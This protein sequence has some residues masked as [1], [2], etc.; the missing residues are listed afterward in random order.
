[1]FQ[2]IQLK[3][4]TKNF[5]RFTKIP[6]PLTVKF[7]LFNVTNS[8][9]VLLGLE[10][11]HFQEVGPFVYQQWR[12][13]EVIDFLDNNRKLVYKEFKTFYP[14]FKPG[15]DIESAS[16]LDPTKHNV[17]IV[18]LPLLTVLTQLAQLEEGSLKRNLAAKAASRLIQAGGE[19]I[20]ITR[21]ANEF[22][23]DGYK[24]GLMESARELIS[25]T[26]GY[27][28]ESP[29]PRNKF[30]FFHTKNGTWSK[31]E[32]GELTVFTGRNNSMDDFM[33]VDNWNGL[34]QLNVWPRNTEAGNRCNE[35]RGTDGSQF[36]P[37]VTRQQVLEIFAPLVCTSIYIKYKEDTS[38]RGIPLFRF[39]TPPDVFAAPKKRPRNA[40]YCTIQTG[41]GNGNGPKSNNNNHLNQQPPVSPADKSQ[42]AS[43]HNQPARSRITNSRC[44]IDGLM[45]LS[46]CQKGAP[47]AASSPHFYNADPMLAMAAGLRPNKELHETYLDIEPMT[48]AVF[49]A[50]SRA[51]LNAYVEQAALEVVDSSLVGQM[52]PMVAPLLW[53]EEAAEIDDKSS[54]EFKGKLLNL[55]DKA[56]RSFLV[57]FV[58]GLLI[59]AAVAVQYW[60]ATCYKID[61]KLIAE[62]LAERRRRSAGGGRRRRDRYEANIRHATG[63]RKSNLAARAGCRRGPSDSKRPLVAEDDEQA[64]AEQA[65]RRP[66]TGGGG[67]KAV[68]MVML[69]VAALGAG[70]AQRR[71]ARERCRARRADYE[72]EDEEEGEEDLSKRALMRNEWGPGEATTRSETSQSE[73]PSA[74]PEGQRRR[75]DDD[76]DNDDEGRAGRGSEASSLS[77]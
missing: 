58:L 2:R 69:A 66:A 27:N 64:A 18:N 77:F 15:V 53:L 44:Y 76:D 32:N 45:D 48:G 60:Y 13:R 8:E 12:R 39:S 5:E 6:I 4:G 21:P 31:K 72:E 70:D 7:Y 54:K 68:P 11:P 73:E 24:V 55:V 71:L 62:E 23:F 65:P 67:P 10:R 25:T 50:A 57:S 42:P 29:L 47:I 20:L 26:L 52:T 1:M 61:T 28:F 9:Q 36:H 14:M 41:N 35:I 37:G 74:R 33:I 34:K 43:G 16:M 56:K 17:T 30:G 75:L 38:T 63:A 46:L 49:R 59:M 40:C 22:L 19:K 51:Q 3:I